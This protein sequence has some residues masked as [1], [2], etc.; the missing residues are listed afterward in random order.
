MI[1]NP[2]L[3][4][5]LFEWDRKTPKKEYTLRDLLSYYSLVFVDLESLGISSETEGDF[6]S[7]KLKAL[8][9]YPLDDRESEVEALLKM[10]KDYG[11]ET[12]LF[13]IDHTAYDDI[14]PTMEQVEQSLEEA[15]KY[16]S[17]IIKG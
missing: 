4:W 7:A 11:L 15:Q 1:T 16:K 9:Y 5:E 10:V 17:N 2:K 12:V 6:Q 8:E 14:Y 13:M 3:H